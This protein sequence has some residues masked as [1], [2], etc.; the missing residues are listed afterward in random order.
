MRFF[1]WKV[2]GG[3]AVRQPQNPTSFVNL[4]RNYIDIKKIHFIHTQ[5]FLLTYIHTYIHDT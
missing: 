2:Q 4:F 5:M 3:V 1:E